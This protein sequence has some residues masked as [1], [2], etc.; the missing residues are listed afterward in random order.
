MKQKGICKIGSGL[1]HGPFVH[2]GSISWSNGTRFWFLQLNVWHG[3]I[4][5]LCLRKKT[6]TVNSKLKKKKKERQ[7][8]IPIPFNYPYL[9][10]A[11]QL[12]AQDQNKVNA[13]N[14]FLKKVFKDSCGEGSWVPALTGKSPYLKCLQERKQCLDA[15]V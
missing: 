5:W 12:Y 13:F 15:K 8:K 10:T 7:K 6:L 3:F 11:R 2:F 1:N 9:R 4:L 14:I